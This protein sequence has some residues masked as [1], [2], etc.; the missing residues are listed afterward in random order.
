MAASAALA[1]ARASSC[2]TVMYAF[3]LPSTA[4][5]R[6]STASVSSTGDISFLRNRGARLAI[7]SNGSRASLIAASAAG[8]R[9][10]VAVHGS[11]EAHVDFAQL[12]ELAAAPAHRACDLAELLIG[13]CQVRRIHD[14]SQRLLRRCLRGLGRGDLRS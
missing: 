13:D 2:I 10:D 6:S 1:A 5:T 9:G 12:R 8:G 4:V 7:V 3:T 14:R 11:R